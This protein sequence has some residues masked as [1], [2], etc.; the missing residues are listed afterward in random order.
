MVMPAL[1]IA[2]TKWFSVKQ[3]AE[4]VV[5]KVG[6]RQLSVEMQASVIEMICSN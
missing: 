2:M 6:G 4:Q 1:K 5:W 3:G